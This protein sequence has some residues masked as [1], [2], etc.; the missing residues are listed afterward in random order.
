MQER[1]P[2]LADVARE[3]GVSVTAASRV[4]NGGRGVAPHVRRRVQAVIDRLAYRPS[5]AARALAAGRADV[6]E[7]VVVDDG[8]CSLGSNPYCGRVVAGIAAELAGSPAQLRIHV[9]DESAAPRRLVEVAGAASLG[10]ILVNVPADLGADFYRRCDRVVS[11]GRSAPR[12]PFIDPDNVA[13]ARAAVDHL[14]RGGRRRLAA[15]HGPERNPCAIGRRTG[16]QEAMRDAGLPPL[17]AGGN[18]RREGG[19]AGTQRLLADHPDLDALFVACDVMAVGALQALAAA[20][21]RVP[22]DVAVVGFDDSLLVSCTIPPLSSVRQPVEEMAATATR[23]LLGGH[24]AAWQSTFPTTLKVRES[25]RPDPRRGR[26]RLRRR[27]AG[28][29]RG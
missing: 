14:Y 8:E 20:G 16:Y 29:P 27:P 23:A 22:D 4:V 2:T 28:W 21:R 10:A 6:V 19:Y 17:G 13:G 11:M 18:F 9:V 24:L 7:L 3:A 12:V 1:R 26:G 15:I 25:S 5:P